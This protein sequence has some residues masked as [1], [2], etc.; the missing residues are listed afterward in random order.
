M[1]TSR[2]SPELQEPGNRTGYCR[3]RRGLPETDSKTK[4]PTTEIQWNYERLVRRAGPAGAW[5]IV[6]IIDRTISA[7]RGDNV[8][9]PAHVRLELAALAIFLNMSGRQVRNLLK[10]LAA[11]ERRLISRHP[12]DPWSYQPHPENF[13]S[14]PVLG[15]VKRPRKARLAAFTMQAGVAAL[16][17]Y[18]HVEKKNIDAGET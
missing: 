5:L 17:T 18:V 9:P 16:R 1:S 8:P 10:F 6:Y 12:N 2:Q 14:A 13:D 3:L 7:Y 4:V 15:A 11:P